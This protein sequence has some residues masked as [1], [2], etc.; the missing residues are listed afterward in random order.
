MKSS[1]LN[2]EQDPDRYKP[3]CQKYINRYRFATLYDTTNKIPVFSAYIFTGPPPKGRPNPPWM[4]EPQLEDIT[5][6]PDMKV[7]KNVINQA[8]EADYNV[9]NKT[10][11]RGHIFPCSY[12]PDE[13]TNKSTFT[14]TN[15]V[16]QERS[17]NRISWC[18][19]ECRVKIKLMTD[20]LDSN[21]KIKAYV[22]TGAVPS[23][24]NKLNDQ[25]NIPSLLWTAYCCYNSNQRQWVAEAHWGENKKGYAPKTVNH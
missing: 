20:C 13:D 15:A 10:I 23:T 2:L 24:N 18:T 6:L 11:D 14:M 12:A 1:V 16:P 3:I 22:V 4:I 21:G 25:V 5:N 7:D 17:F 8:A 9:K 19:M